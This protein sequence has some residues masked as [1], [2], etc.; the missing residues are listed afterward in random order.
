MVSTAAVMTSKVISI[1]KIW[2]KSIIIEWIIFLFSSSEKQSWL[3]FVTSFGFSF[4]EKTKK[5]S[6]I[7]SDRTNTTESTQ[8]C[9]Q[10]LVFTNWDRIISILIWTPFILGRILH[11]SL[12]T[13]QGENWPI[14]FLIVSDTSLKLLNSFLLS[15]NL[16]DCCA[17]LYWWILKIFVCSISILV[18]K[19]KIIL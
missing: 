13:T 19:F 9:D 3:G 8:D 15:L 7:S 1:V 2:I 11:H 17:Y 6:W 10:H 14:L 18:L 5:Y 4:I 12:E 16:N